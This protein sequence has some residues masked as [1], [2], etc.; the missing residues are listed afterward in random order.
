[1][2]T[3]YIQ[4]RVGFIKADHKI[5]LSVAFGGNAMFHFMLL[6]PETHVLAGHLSDVAL[7]LSNSPFLR[8]SLI[9]GHPVEVR[10]NIV[11]D[12]VGLSVR[13]SGAD[14]RFTLTPPEAYRLADLFLEA[15]VSGG[16]LSK[17]EAG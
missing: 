12:R 9:E 15:L 10:A 3:G 6:P 16:W 11:D 4:V 5:V 7:R 1:V 8:G 17:G 14:V 13:M 2:D